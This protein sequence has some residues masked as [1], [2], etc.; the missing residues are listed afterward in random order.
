MLKSLVPSVA[1]LQS[2]VDTLP[3]LL[4][5]SRIPANTPNSPSTPETPASVVP[6][7]NT[8]PR[9]HNSIINATSTTGKIKVDVELQEKVECKVRLCGCRCHKVF[10]YQNNP[11]VAMMVGTLFVGYSGIP[12]VDR[13]AC[14]EKKGIK[15]TGG[16]LKLTYYFPSWVPLQRMLSFVDKWQNPEIHHMRLQLPRLVPATSEIFALA[17][18]GN[19]QGI[20]MMFDT[21]KASIYDVSSGEGRSVLHVRRR[22]RQRRREADNH[23]SMP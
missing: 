9:L 4:M 17:Q 7:L 20:S 19:V 15:E 3:S 18:K 14:N 22:V 2:S 8:S 5:A 12:F 13:P 1:K 16:L 10:R 11:W 21:G 6:V 23:T